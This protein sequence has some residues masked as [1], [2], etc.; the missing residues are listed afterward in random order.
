MDLFICPRD[1][2]HATSRFVPTHLVSLQD[3]GADSSIVDSL[4]PAWIP[5]ENH[6]LDYFY[7][8]DFEV[9]GEL[10]DRVPRR[11]QIA[12]LI[13]WMGPRCGPGSSNRLL[14]HCDAGLGRSP[15]AGYI[16][17]AI[18]FG[19]RREAE[20]FERMV[21]SSLET[22]LVPNSIMIALADEILDRRGE[23]KPPLTQWNARVPWRRTM[24]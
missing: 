21:A 1:W 17:W 2:T 6:Y 19:E 7:D 16:A 24:R 22:Q 14:I 11:E 4:R 5:P 15:A 18:H 20:A 12:N 3:P 8:F 10:D 23:L 13:A 9:S